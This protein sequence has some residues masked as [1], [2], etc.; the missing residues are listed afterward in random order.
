MPLLKLAEILIV[1][2]AGL[3]FYVWQMRQL[4][5]DRAQPAAEAAAREQAAAADAHG[6]LDRAGQTPLQV[7][8]EPDRGVQ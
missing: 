6:H 4:K 8:R 7:P 5:R 3:A 1:V 2:G